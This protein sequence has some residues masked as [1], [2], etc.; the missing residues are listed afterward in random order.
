M[1][2][3][4]A[5]E[6]QIADIAKSITSL[7]DDFLEAR[8]VRIPT[9]DVQMMAEGAVKPKDI[10]STEQRIYGSDYDELTR[11][12]RSILSLAEAEEE[13]EVIDIQQLRLRRE[14][15]EINCGRAKGYDCEGMMCT[16]GKLNVT[17]GLESF[18]KEA[19]RQRKVVPFFKLNEREMKKFFSEDVELII[20]SCTFR[21]PDYFI[22]QDFS[23]LPEYSNMI[24]FM[25]RV[26]D[27][28]GGIILRYFPTREEAEMIWDVY[29]K[30]SWKWVPGRGKRNL[31]AA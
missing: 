24:S 16:Q 25:V 2:N 18:A 20:D 10:F 4:I 17:P 1:D 7:V 11:S 13:P 5:K 23:N 12:I 28:F 8:G 27:S 14:D 21:I 15:I 26:P 31:A 6:N 9:S 30:D 3:K 29:V 19:I 22:G